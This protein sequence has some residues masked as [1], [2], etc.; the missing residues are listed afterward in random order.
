MWLEM[1]SERRSLLSLSGWSVHDKLVSLCT[2]S[3][4]GIVGFTLFA[5]AFLTGCNETQLLTG[6]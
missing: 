3:C 2:A 1:P 5:A 4:G 6:L